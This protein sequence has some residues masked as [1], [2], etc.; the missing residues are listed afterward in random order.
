VVQ[1]NLGNAFIQRIR[2][3]KA[4]NLERAIAHFEWALTVL[5]CDGHPTDWA[6][7]QDSL[8]A[9]YSQRILGDMT[10]N[11]ERA[12]AHHEA[13]LTIHTRN[14]FPIVWA[15]TQNN[16]AV[17][18]SK[19][20]R[21]LTA[22]NLERSI[23]HYEA[24]ATV[25]TREAFPAD[26]AM[27]QNNLATG[28]AERIHGESA[29]NIEHAIALREAALT[30]YSREDFP[31]AW[32]TTQQSLAAD[33]RKRGSGNRAENLEH[34]I[35]L[36]EAALTVHTRKAAPIQ[37]AIIHHNLGLAYWERIVGDETE[38]RKRAIEHYEA[39]LIVRTHE[40]FPADWAMT[41]SNLANAYF[42]IGGDKNLDH[43][44]ALYE[45]ALTVCTREI[46]P[47]EHL[48]LNALLGRALLVKRQWNRALAALTEARTT[49]L[50][51]FGEGLDEVEAR[52]LIE[53][54]GLLF[55]NAAYAAAV[56]GALDQA[57]DFLCQG[58][59]RLMAAALR[60]QT[61][62]LSAPSRERTQRLRTQIREQR[63]LLE[64]TSG[65]ARARVLDG[66]A[67]L[68]KDLSE[69]IA[70][71]EATSNQADTLTL[72][73]VLVADGSAIVV[74]FLT[75]GGGKILIVTRTATRPEITMLDL[76]D[77]ETVTL[78]IGDKQRGSH[79]W[80]Q[81]CTNIGPV[82]WPER[83]AHAA[84]CVET[85]GQ[86]IWDIFAGAL[87]A[88]LKCLGVMPGSRLFFLPSELLGYLPIGLA[89]ETSSSE[90]LLEIYDIVYA[91]SL[92]ALA[93][94]HQQVKRRTAPSLAAI[95]NPTGDLI[96]AQ[97]EG[98][99]V[100]GHFDEN[101][102]VIMDQQS[103]S[104]EA[105]LSSLEG[106]SYW[107]FSTHGNFD[108]RNPRRS[109]LAMKDG[110]HL[111]VSSL[112]EAEGLGR[113]RLVVLSACE[114]G[115][116]DFADFTEEFVGLPGAFMTI[117]AAAVLATLWQ[118]D[119]RATALL[120]ARFYDFHLI[121]GLS[122]TA[123]LRRAQLWLRDATRQDLIDYTRLAVAQGWISAD[124]AHQV[125]LALDNVALEAV[126]FFH[127]AP[128][129][130]GVTLGS[131]RP[132]AHPIYWGGFVLTGI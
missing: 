75:Y 33:Y 121:D 6:T 99:L 72:A 130:T 78:L 67:E 9:A 54:G 128:P 89:Q 22:E 92:I 119:D 69:L 11:L 32:A 66:L 5:T 41:Q 40:A 12:I 42:D 30:V 50:L 118:V 23:A 61:L 104:A 81:A 53:V 70:E 62:D 129:R 116:H 82:V 110:T 34:A 124:Q 1:H 59:A 115:L 47:R 43:A 36:N 68:R 20:V 83:K 84:R 48:R 18:Y 91:P 106:K 74:P 39:A 100:A 80:L 95:V 60:V 21:G 113:P 57:F 88:S 108:F 64:A 16:L 13:A 26:W 10:E 38:N 97:I 125:E 58:R 7:T 87:A 56:L 8:G 44:I 27:T 51:L 86:Q 103:A 117:G 111:S 35:T 52:E 2:G 45:A 49:F 132:F 17:A 109:A 105:T 127:D 107:H 31:A 120:I 14:D 76:P 114:T 102:R 46:L 126:R 96:F 28:Y 101:C 25:Y 24:A 131:E 90:R 4:E 63:R 112:L 29:E 122:P 93:K 65:M 73:S 98:A 123:A 85:I 55:V 3:E 37:W 79:G 19:R 71:T 77:D 94:A 15:G